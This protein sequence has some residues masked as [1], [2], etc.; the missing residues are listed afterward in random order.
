MSEEQPEDRDGEWTPRPDP[1]RL[2]T[3]SLQ[4]EIAG[5]REILEGQIKALD[6]KISMQ[7][8]GTEKATELLQRQAERLPSEIDQKLA[9]LAAVYLEKFHSVEGRLLERDKRFEQGSNDAKTALDTALAAQ[10]RSTAAALS[11]AKEAVEKSEV[12][13]A[14]QIDQLGLQGHTVSQSLDS[15]ITDLKDRLEAAI[16]SVA[17]RSEAAIAALRAE[18][19][20]QITGER[21]R[22]DRGEGRTIGQGAMIALMFGIISAVGVIG[23]IVV[24][25]MKIQ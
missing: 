15:K 2:T 19:L 25:I 13:F 11:S 7:L 16:N 6:A 4:R 23:G 14:K 20:P 1:T 5:L 22:G 18:L 10:M 21:T 3:L 8:D 9:A 12:A 17:L 24:L